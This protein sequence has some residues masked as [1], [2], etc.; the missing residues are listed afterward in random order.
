MAGTA[1]TLLWL[2]GSFLLLLWS[3]AMW[4]AHWL[5]SLGNKFAAMNA[6][7]IPGSPDWMKWLAATARLFAGYGEWAAV[8]IWL[9]VSVIVLWALRFVGRLLE[10]D[11][12]PEKH[13]EDVASSG[14]F[15]E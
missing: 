5:V 8:G 13:I 2:L 4:A 10:I 11:R 3:G 14:D 9:L 6:D 7:R 15:S 12:A 1:K